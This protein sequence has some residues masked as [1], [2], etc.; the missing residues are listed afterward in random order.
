MLN[1][2]WDDDDGDDD[3]GSVVPDT[4]TKASATSDMSYARMLTI[5]EETEDCQN[6]A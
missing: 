3:A 1:T 2:V 5:H 6:S 4:P